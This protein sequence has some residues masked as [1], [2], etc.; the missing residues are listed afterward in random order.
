MNPCGEVRTQVGVP[1]RQRLLVIPD[2]LRLPIES[3]H[4]LKRRETRDAVSLLLHLQS[5]FRS[6]GSLTAYA[7][8]CC[9]AA[10]TPSC[11]IIPKASKLV[12]ASTILPSESR[13]MV[14]PII[15]IRLPVGGTEGLRLSLVG[16]AAPEAHRDLVTFGHYVLYGVLQIRE[17]LTEG[18]GELPGPFY[19]PHLPGGG[20]MTDVVW[21]ED[22]LDNVEV[23]R[24]VVELLDLPTQH[25][26]VLFCRH[27]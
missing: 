18:G 21:G 1:D 23:A 4:S 27:L 2:G 10:I 12:H 13:L 19:A 5:P 7:S 15:S 11:R 26:L 8:A 9:G 14:M 20:L 24:V 25:G 22:L 3:L 17:G 6:D 16:T